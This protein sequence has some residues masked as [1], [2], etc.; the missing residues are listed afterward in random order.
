[1]DLQ[2]MYQNPSLCCWLGGVVAISYLLYGY[3]T[4][5][6]FGYISLSNIWALFLMRICLG[7]S[8]LKMYVVEACVP[9]LL[10]TELAYVYLRTY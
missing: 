6:F 9:W 3:L 1:M 4:I 5:M 10:F 2:L 8:R 7:Q